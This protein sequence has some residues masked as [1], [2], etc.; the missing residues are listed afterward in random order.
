MHMEG[1][2]HKE[3]DLFNIFKQQEQF[4]KRPTNTAE[5]VDY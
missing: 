5:S 1:W 4:F 3:S 2:Y